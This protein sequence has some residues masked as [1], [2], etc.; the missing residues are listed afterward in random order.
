MI[1]TPTTD[2]RSTDQHHSCE[3]DFTILCEFAMTEWLIEN[4]NLLR[5][6]PRN[7]C[8]VQHIF[9]GE[10]STSTFTGPHPNSVETE[11]FVTSRVFIFSTQLSR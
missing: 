11:G 7:A 4:Y 5:P 1:Q 6:F 2:R 9:M 3:C 10:I 8:Y